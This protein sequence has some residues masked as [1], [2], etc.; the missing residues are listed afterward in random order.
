[1]LVVGPMPLDMAAPR[2]LSYCLCQ[3]KESVYSSLSG[4]ETRNIPGSIII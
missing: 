2:F 4:L 3:D 1:M